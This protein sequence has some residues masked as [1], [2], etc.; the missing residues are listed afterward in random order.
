V[1]IAALGSIIAGLAAFGYVRYRT[2][3]G[4]NP[5]SVAGKIR[6]SK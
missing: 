3:L 1:G 6:G 2:R 4:T 5:T